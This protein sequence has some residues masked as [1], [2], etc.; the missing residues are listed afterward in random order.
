MLASIR[1]L[2][3]RYTARVITTAATV[4]VTMATI[5]VTDTVDVEV[6]FETAP[7]V[8]DEAFLPPFFLA[9]EGESL[10]LCVDPQDDDDLPIFDPLPHCVGDD[11]VGDDV[12]TDVVGDDVGANV[13]GDDVGADVVGDDVGADVVGDDVGADVVGD[14]V[15]AGHGLMNKGNPGHVP[16]SGS[17]KGRG[18]PK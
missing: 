11:V 17:D 15:G 6:G 12:G 2:V 5:I 4:T 7:T 10:V 3:R 13:V 1:A 14:D 9:E 16:P 18:P 8:S